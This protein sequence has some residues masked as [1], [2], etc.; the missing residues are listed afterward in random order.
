MLSAQE[1]EGEGE[2]PDYEDPLPSGTDWDSFV[3]RKGDQVF[4][5]S[6]GTNFPLAILGDSG[7]KMDNNF[8][9]P[10]GGV[11][12]P[13]G[14]SIFL[15]DKLPFFAGAEIAFIINPTLSESMLFMIP[16]GLRVGWLFNINHFEFPLGLTV[17]VALQRLLDFN[18]VGLF[19]KGGVS[20]FYRFSPDWSFGLNVDASW[21]PQW[22]PKEEVTG[23]SRN[24]HGV[25]L[26][27]TL[28]ARYHF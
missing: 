24:A 1:D 11:I 10:V 17:G 9:P 7:E 14:Y 27:V 15:S 8:V 20:A 5:L 12:G 21:Y 19:V 16:L 2:E 26:G 13:I 23:I 4:T 28:S 6:L 22:V 25:F 3:Y 18:Y